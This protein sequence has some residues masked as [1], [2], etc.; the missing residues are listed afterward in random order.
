MYL[1]RNA[2]TAGQTTTPSP[3]TGTLLAVALPVVGLLAVAL[4]AGSLFAAAPSLAAPGEADRPVAHTLPG[5]DRSWPVGGR[6][7]VVHGWDPPAS[8]YGPGHRGVD[9]AAAP[10]TPVRAAAPG[11][12]TFAGR[13]AGRGVLTITVAGTQ[14]AYDVRTGTG[15]RRT[16]RRGF[17]GP[18]GRGP[19]GRAVPLPVRVPALGAAARGDLSEPA[20]DAP[21]RDAAPGSVT[22]APGVRDP[23]AD[24]GGDAGRGPGAAPGNGR[25]LGAPAPLTPPGRGNQEDRPGPANRWP[26]HGLQPRTPLSAIATAASATAPGSSTAPVSIRRTAAST[27]PWSSIAASR[28]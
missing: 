21:A 22:A 12:I 24:S 9:L 5:G 11:R 1:T 19:G 7:R 14:L 6:P 10:G 8:P 20:D 16:G 23:R 2:R 15:A 4:L 18:G 28:G 26:A 25:G 13:V 17:R 3:R 27:T